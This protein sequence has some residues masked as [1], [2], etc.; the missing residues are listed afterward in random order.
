MVSNKEGRE[1]FQRL[2]LLET[3]IHK[4]DELHKKIVIFQLNLA[5]KDENLRPI[6]VPF[7]GLKSSAK[8]LFKK[9]KELEFIQKLDTKKLIQAIKG[10]K[11]I[12]PD[13]DSMLDEDKKLHKIEDIENARLEEI[14]KYTYKIFRSH[15]PQSYKP[16]FALFA[17]AIEII[18]TETEQKRSELARVWEEIRQLKKG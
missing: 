10:L 18:K 16:L 12:Y 8:E 7:K 13:L 14:F 6:V 5:G 17:Q 15:N 9:I 4:L 3:E 2:K 1:L 11:K